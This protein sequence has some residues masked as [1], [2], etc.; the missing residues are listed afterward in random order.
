MRQSKEY[1]LSP[2]FPIQECLGWLFWTKITILGK[3]NS[4]K[5]SQQQQEKAN[6]QT[7]QNPNKED[8]EKETNLSVSE[9]EF[10][11]QHFF[12]TW[13]WNGK[14]SEKFQDN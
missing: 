5:N 8:M 4:Q 10:F 6:N 1:R 14:V 9:K 2:L 12:L 7:P 11:K 3:K 13:D